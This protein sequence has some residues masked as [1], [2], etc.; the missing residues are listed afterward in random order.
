[1][2]NSGAKAALKGYRLQTL[3]ILNEIFHTKNSELIYQPEGREDLA[4]YD[5]ERLIRVVQVKARSEPL[6]L[7]SFSPE[8]EDSFFHRITKLLS[9]NGNVAIEIASF[10]DIGNEI[11]KACSGDN[12]SQ[13]KIKNKLKNHGVSELDTQK[14]FQKVSWNK[15]SETELVKGFNLL[16]NK[17]VTA[18]NPEHALSLLTSWL[19]IASEKRT[20]VTHKELVEKLTAIGKYFSER[21]AHHQEWFKSILPLIDDADIDID[22]LSK[23]YYKGVS[24]RFTH[25][26]ANLDVHRKVLL[27]KIDELLK[28]NRTLIIHG[29]SG[30]GKTSLAFRYLYDYIPEEWRF[31][32]SFIEDRKHAQTITA[33]IAD[34]LAVFKVTVHIYIDVSPRDADWTMLVKSLMDKANVKVIVC[35]REE[36][37]ARQN[38]S[39]EELGLPAFLPVNFAKSEAKEIYTTLVNQGIAKLFP[40]ADQA[41][42]TFG[43]EGSLLEFIYFLT[44]TESLE[45]KLRSQV[46]RIRNEVSSGKLEKHAINLLLGCAIATA[47]EARIQIGVMAKELNLNDPVGV[48]SLFENEYLLRRSTDKKYIEALHPIRSRILSNILVDPAFYPW[49]DAV[50]IVISSLVESDLDTFLL[51]SFLEH[52]M[53]FESVFQ[54][55]I[56]SKL[57]TWRGISGVCKALLWHGISQHAND[58]NEVIT[59]AREF[60]GDSGWKFLLLPDFAK[61]FEVNPVDEVIDMLGKGNPEAI[62][63]SKAL[64]AAISSP[65]DV[66]NHLKLFLKNISY[67]IEQPHSDSDWH[68]LCEVLIWLSHLKI[69][70]S[71]NLSWVINL[72]VK[73]C[74][75][76]IEPLAALTLGL[77]LFK[78]DLYL[79]FIEKN[80]CVIEELFQYSTDTLWL[81]HLPDNPI[82][83]YIISNDHIENSEHSSFNDLSVR[84]AKLL[85]ILFPN[86]EKFGAKGYGHQVHC[87]ELPLDESEKTGILKSA[88]PI[89]QFVDVNAIWANYADF[90]HRS[91][92]WVEYTNNILAIREKLTGGL[93]LLNNALVSYFKKNKSISIIGWKINSKYWEGLSKTHMHVPMLPKIAVD[94]WG[95]TSEGTVHSK[96]EKSSNQATI[97]YLSIQR[98]YQGYKKAL[99]DY[100]SSITNFYNQSHLILMVNGLIG[101]LPQEQHEL[102]FRKAEE[103]GQNY[104]KHG[105]HLSVVNLDDA[106]KHLREMQLE[107]RKQF[108]G[109]V[110]LNTLKKTETKE[111]EKFN[112]V[113]SLWF[114]FAHSPENHW[115]TSPES[116]ALSIVNM[117]RRSLLDKIVN[118]LNK[119][120]S[121]DLTTE[122]LNNGYEC[123]G[124]KSLWITVSASKLASLDVFFEEMVEALT[125]A[126]RPLEYRDLKYFVMTNEWEQFVIIPK[127]NGLTLSHLSWVIQTASFAGEQP[128]LDEEKQWLYLPRPIEASAIKYFGLETKH[129]S[130]YSGLSELEEGLAGIYGIVNHMHCFADLVPNINET[131]KDILTNYLTGLLPNLKE[132]VDSIERLC[133]NFDNVDEDLQC[134]LEECQHAALPYDMPD[135]NNINIQ[136]SD[137]AEWATLLNEAISE[138]QLNKWQAYSL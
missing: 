16:L 4:I 37:L 100:V 134:V 20:K 77:Y 110:D 25:I 106:R 46:K 124:K 81:E 99:G 125:D 79:Q 97:N 63:K 80:R 98:Q 43:G 117:E 93:V 19:Y 8:K 90:I 74:F 58:N 33:A 102:I 75:S 114:Q 65:D 14:L 60:T 26:Q 30:Q 40:S 21:A 91:D 133:E 36:D 57:K 88:I 52:P 109:I 18:G 2:D 28:T 27:Q 119:L 45:E 137:C 130:H 101:R 62:A 129:A 17:T 1:M 131:G 41:W 68:G 54:R 48:L 23:E 135:D 38:I 42:V 104:S 111:T 32:I 66:F 24:S 10:G 94:P 95:F 49:E 84:R 44:Q 9:T 86:N 123:D 53:E 59:Q 12:S 138:L 87:M 71:L 92:D 29:A 13:N 89:K 120:A 126:I 7:S 116:R 112:K 128:I 115:K 121:N 51:Y 118:S 82:A 5:G 34:H 122:I 70:V 72:D 85:R 22:S 127:V 64:K 3:F 132:H 50:Q 107:F 83:H 73:K 78:T 113:W 47:Y 61:I 11:K 6:V 55:L 136:L 67:E 96:D 69:N 15:V 105:L 56:K 103:I 108:E 35:I 76:T 31:H 39:N